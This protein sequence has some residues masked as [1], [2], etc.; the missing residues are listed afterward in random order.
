[1][2]FHYKLF[3]LLKEWA[4]GHRAEAT[5]GLSCV[6]V[7]VCVCTQS[8]TLPLGMLIVLCSESF[9]P[10]VYVPFLSMLV[11]WRW[12][13]CMHWKNKNIMYVCVAVGMYFVCLCMRTCV[14]V[15]TI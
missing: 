8:Y 7:C 14:R 3:C 1:M 13:I 2:K 12:H 9:I 4:A 6:Y 15:Y 11:L 10:R 5:A